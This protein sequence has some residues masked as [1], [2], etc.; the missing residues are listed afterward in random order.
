MQGKQPSQRELFCTIDLETFVPEDH[1]LRKLDRVVDL[2]FLYALTE[3]LYCASNG[4]PSIDPVLFFRMQL[5]G[6]LYSIDSDRQLC[7]DVH[8]NLA[9]RWFCRIPL[10]DDVPHHSSLTRIRDRLGED[11]YRAIFE[12]L[13]EQWRDQGHVGGKSVVADATLVEAE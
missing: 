2:E 4:R 9:Y 11:K 12:R 5:I 10:Q 1:L 13:L 6:C 8:L 7:R 3:D